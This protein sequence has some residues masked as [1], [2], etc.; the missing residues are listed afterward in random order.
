MEQVL[1]EILEEIAPEAQEM[2]DLKGACERI[3]DVAEKLRDRYD[4]KP[5]FCGSIAKDT[6]LR[7]KKD[8][9]F[10]LLFDE[11]LEPE[12]LED[13][14][15]EA[16]K[17]IIRELGGEWKVAYAEHPYVQGEVEGYG[18][19]GVDIVPA[20]DVPADQIKSSV[21]RTPWHVRWIEKNLSHEQRDQVRLLKKF[22]K[23][24]GLYGSDLRTKGFSGYLCELLIA[25]YGSFGSLVQE[26]QDWEAGTVIDSEDH[27]KS[28]GYVKREKFEGDALTVVDPVDKD[29]NVASVLSSENF[30]LFRKSA[31]RFLENPGRDTFFSQEAEP[32]DLQELRERID[33]RGTDFLLIEFEAPDVHQDVLFPQMR[34]LN[35]RLEEILQ[36]EGFVVLRKDEWSDQ[37]SCVLIL[38]LEVDELPRIDKR[39][40]PPIFDTRNSER[41]IKRYE[42][43][44]N[45]LVENNR[46]YAEYFRD[47]TTAL[48][49]VREFLQEGSEELQEEG[50]P[51]HL[52]EKITEGLSIATSHHSYRIFRKHE[53][54]RVKMR[55][56]FEKDL[57]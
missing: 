47:F 38:E 17:E 48:D 22:C 35:S 3:K 18:V 49:F 56:Y 30:F 43:E 40:G 55:E 8:I 6:W 54:L 20:Y 52:A 51:R 31:A 50:V 45:L 41:F 19:D 24:Q 16:A 13:R 53:G 23:E 33:E 37:E 25:E 39:H 27:F 5:L 11:D 12:E 42:G 46:W 2:E 32:L 28:H 29:R 34:K 57:T 44:H 4:Y 1:E 36:D 7:S 26:V 15:V 21:D 10:F 14:G 9:D